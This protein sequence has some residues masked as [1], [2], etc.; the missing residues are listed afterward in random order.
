MRTIFIT[1]LLFKRLNR[2]SIRRGEKGQAIL[3]VAVVAVGIV[4]MVGLAIDGGLGYL[5]SQ[6]MQRAAD[7]A[8]LA[9]VIWIPDNREVADARAQLSAESNGI[10]VACYYNNAATSTAVITAYNNRC[11][12]SNWN[13]MIQKPPDE[14]FY[15]ESDTPDTGGVRYRVKLAKL[16]TRFFLGVIGFPNYPILRTAVAE[17]VGASRGLGSSFNYLGTQGVEYDHYMRCD[18][19]NP[20]ACGSTSTGA[21]TVLNYPGI[22]Y[23]RY[24]LMNC[25]N[26]DRGVNQNCTQTFWNSISGPSGTHAGDGGNSGYNGGD[27]FNPIRDGG[28]GSTGSQCMHT[29]TMIT[30]P[31]TLKPNWYGEWFIPSQNVY[32]DNSNGSS[33]NCDEFTNA[34]QT[35]PIRNQDT[36]QDQPGVHGFGYEIGIEVD[37]AAI[38]SYSDTISDTTKHTNLNVTIFDGAMN[39]IGDV[40]VS[41]GSGPNDQYERPTYPNGSNTNVNSLVNNNIYAKSPYWNF[42]EN[43]SAKIITQTKFFQPSPTGQTPTR[44]LTNGPNAVNYTQVITNNLATLFPDRNNLEL[45]YNDMR[46]RYTLYGPPS[47]PGSPS[48]YENVKDKFIGSMEMSDMS[49]RKAGDTGNGGSGGSIANSNN[50]GLKKCYVIFD[51][52]KAFWDNTRLLKIDG[53]TSASDTTTEPSTRRTTVLNTSNADKVG[54]GPDYSII[55]NTTS[56]AS[57][58]RYDYVCNDSALYNRVTGTPTARY[59]Y[60]YN[61][62]PN[63]NA[64]QHSAIKANSPFS[65]ID[66]NGSTFAAT[67]DLTEI[68]VQN[69]LVKAD[70]SGNITTTNTILNVIPNDMVLTNQDC[71]P[72]AV[73]RTGTGNDNTSTTNG[74]TLSYI[75]DSNNP[76]GHNR[77]PFNMAYGDPLV[78]RAWLPY[79]NA[80]GSLYTGGNL[81][82]NTYYS[83]YYSF[84]GWRCD[85]DFDSSYSYDSRVGRGNRLANPSLPPSESNFSLSRKERAMATYDGQYDR[86]FVMGHPGLTS[87]S[88]LK[89]VLQSSGLITQ[90]V[91]PASG[92]WTEREMQTFYVDGATN[93]NSDTSRP[94]HPFDRDFGL[95]PYFHLSNLAWNATGDG[96]VVI[97]RADGSPFNKSDAPVRSGTYMLHVQTFGGIGANRYS[98]KAEYENAKNVVVSGITFRP[99]PE[100]YGVTSLSLFISTNKTQS[101]PNQKIIMDLGFIPSNLHDRTAIMEMFDPADVSGRVFPEIYAPNGYGPKV[102]YNSNSATTNTWDIVPLG[103]QLVYRYSFCNYS[104]ELATVPCTPPVTPTGNSANIACQDCWALVSFTIPSFSKYQTYDTQ[105]AA[106][107]IPTN[108]CYFFITSFNLNGT[109]KSYDGMTWQLKLPND[110]PH[111]VNDE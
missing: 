64:N 49:I 15:F 26:P 80:A 8:A 86:Q 9:G 20:V 88:Y 45:T 72:S 66:Y 17:Y 103:D 38:W 1:P 50:G 93:P 57:Q 60:F 54:A 85:W 89:S 24:A 16:Q 65:G 48:T 53:S 83:V 62:K 61:A 63:E 33:G 84:H 52:V 73:A 25:D 11:K 102:N 35:N 104:L 2:A 107:G 12:R 56:T 23:Q 82:A 90:G 37:P 10:K 34:A 81:Y 40:D 105:C 97:K 76:W 29:T 70:A 5:E 3:L 7:A 68:T 41:S 32:T 47:T 13:E 21:N 59:N 22:I 69:S 31:T 109:A 111:L 4:A 91:N 110:P 19:T 92:L 99:V 46:T 14:R 44:V 78:N 71:L 106:N 28:A 75:N 98:V 67:K 108:Q 36:N 18:M 43:H 87:N 55:T 94:V 51:D 27:A 39:E 58:S 100:V 95:Q 101:G 42:A 6:R 77:I 79:T 74:R 30:T 96:L